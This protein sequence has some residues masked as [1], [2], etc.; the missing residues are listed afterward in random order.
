MRMT[1]QVAPD[2][3]TGCAACVEYCPAVAKGQPA[4]K[5]I[6]MAPQAPIADRERANWNS[7]LD[8]PEA[9]RAA[10][11]VASIKG[12]QLLQPLFEFSGA[13]AG[14]GETPYI[15][16][17]SQMFGDRIL[18]ANATGCSSIYGG[19]LP[20]T[21]WAMN[22]LGR[23]PGWADSLFED[24]AEFGLGMRVALD[25]RLQ[26]ARALLDRLAAAVGEQAV[27]A[28]RAG[29]ADES[30]AGMAAQRDRVQRLRQQLA[31]IK[32]AEAAQLSAL[33]D[34]FVHRAVWIVG[35]DGWAYDIGFGGL[36]Q[37]AAQY[38]NVYVA[39]VA[40]GADNQQTI[41]AFAEAAA[42]RVRRW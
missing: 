28:I 30:E 42:H 12:S 4:H 6:D 2:D 38:G 39:T 37:M 26:T 23:G 20:T 36:D 22:V 7:F 9:N 34:A 33:A 29:E 40:I 16:L 27:S 1:I 31:G 21:P 41:T 17:L 10:L 19:N 13:C 14:C 32:G 5:A 25:M 11:K 3:C 18:V 8:I 24:N 15:K 35:G